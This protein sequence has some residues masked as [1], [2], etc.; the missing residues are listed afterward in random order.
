MVIPLGK[1]EWG[2]IVAILLSAGSALF[3]AGIVYGEV[4]AQDKRILV[5]ETKTAAIEAQNNTANERLAGIEAN[6]GWLVDQYKAERDRG[7]K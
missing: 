1:L 3:S 7:N 4:K 2:V 5:V 6:L